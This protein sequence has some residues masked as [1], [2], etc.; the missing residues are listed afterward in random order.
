MRNDSIEIGVV[1]PA[2]RSRRIWYGH[3]SSRLVTENPRE[4]PPAA[5]IDEAIAGFE[6]V[7]EAA[8]ETEAGAGDWRPVKDSLVANLAA[9]LNALDRQREQLAALLHRIDSA[10]V[11]N[12]RCLR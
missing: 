3:G 11:A 12:H 9:Q 6:R 2:R 4:L 10:P 7:D 1:N 5:V 8:T